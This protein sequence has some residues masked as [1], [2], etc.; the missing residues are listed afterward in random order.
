MK[1]FKFFAAALVVL[2][3]ASCAHYPDDPT[4]SVWSKGLWILPW[5]T[6]LGSI[7]FFY[8]AYQASK[9]NS[10][11]NT[12]KGKIDNTG[13]VSIFKTGQFWFGVVLVIATI[14][15][16]AVVNGNK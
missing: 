4:Q 9:S 14:V 2:L 7:P 6:G 8:F 1:Q 3:F 12:N 5:L 13:N 10:T 11:T 16:I 15:I